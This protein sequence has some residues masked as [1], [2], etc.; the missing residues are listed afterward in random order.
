MNDRAFL[1]YLTAY[2]F[3]FGCFFSLNNH[4]RFVLLIL[5]AVIHKILGLKYDLT[6]N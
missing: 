6:K 1:H 5:A 2:L 3:L 4:L